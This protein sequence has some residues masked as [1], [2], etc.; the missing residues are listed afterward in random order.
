MTVRGQFEGNWSK[1]AVA[2]RQM[3]RNQVGYSFHVEVI[4]S[5]NPGV[6]DRQLSVSRDGMRGS[7][8]RL[9]QPPQSVYLA[10]LKSCSFRYERSQVVE[11][12]LQG[13]C[14]VDKADKNGLNSM[15]SRISREGW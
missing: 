13:G 11:A 7:F 6:Q 10:S 3:C 14:D 8:A 12:L 9:L 1:A 15:T 4:P 5:S 2:P